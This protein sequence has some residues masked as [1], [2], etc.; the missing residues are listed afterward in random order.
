MMSFSQWGNALYSGEKSYA[1]VPKRKILLSATGVVV[2]LALILTLILGVNRS[3][4]FTGGSQF[5]LVGV[6]NTSQ[7]LAYDALTSSGLGSNARVSNV[8]ADGIRVQTDSLTSEQTATV[9]DALAQAYGVSATDV[10]SSSIGPSWGKDVTNKAI[11]SLLIFLGLVGL[12]MAAYFRSWSMSVAAL[13]ALLHDVIIT[14]G[15]FAVV[16]VEVSPAT[17]IGFLTILGYSLYD[18]VVV[19]DKVREL[20]KDIHDQRRY[21]YAELVN[22]AVNQTLVRS[23]NTSVVALLPVGAILII[24]SLLLGAGTLTDIS[25][26][27]FVGMIAG[28]YSSIFIASPLLVAIEERRGRTR[29]HDEAVAAERARRARKAASSTTEETRSGV[30]TA[31]PGMPGQHLGRQAQPKRKKNKR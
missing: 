23:I 20:T 13:V 11:Q 16:R 26:A 27:L 24:G 30:V 9:R 10:Q 6:S 7:Q 5:T 25:L 21:T 29:E 2:L 3:I 12:L 4:E 14:I 1:V 15:F 28:T 19:F 31:A 8:G 18:T 22:L 17:V